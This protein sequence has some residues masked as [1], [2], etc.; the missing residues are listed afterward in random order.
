MFFIMREHVFPCWDDKHN[1]DGGC[2]SL[3]VHGD[4]IVSIWDELT[5][6][7]IGETM[8][9]SPTDWS[10]VNGV[11][12]SPKRGFC[13]IKLWMSSD[14]VPSGNGDDADRMNLPCK[15]RGDV[16]YR[17]NRQNIQLD[18]VK[19]NNNAPLSSAICKKSV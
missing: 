1:I 9:R 8:M 4:Q 11:S 16:V 17:S 12:I 7:V 6:R 18:A 14:Y 5:K 15:Y 2:I 10:H 19:T 13:I 3:K